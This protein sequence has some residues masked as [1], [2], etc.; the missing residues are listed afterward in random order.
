MNQTE[1]EAYL[2][3]YSSLK[4]AGKPF[5]PYA[6]AKDGLMAVFVM[7]PAR[8]GTSSSSSKCCG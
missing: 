4:N 2:R 1:K 3:E 7:I 6:V 8:T 5:F